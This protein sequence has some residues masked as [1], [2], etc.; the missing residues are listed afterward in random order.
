MACSAASENYGNTA[1]STRVEVEKALTERDI[2]ESGLRESFR[3]SRSFSIPPLT[4]YRNYCP[5]VYPE[6]IPDSGMIFGV[7]LVDVATNQD[8]V[9]KVIKICIEEVEKGG[10]DAKG[11]YSVSQPC[12][13]QDSFTHIWCHRKELQPV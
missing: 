8:N 3:R 7:P 6:M 4:F 1:T 13:C 12:T 11:I 10:L 5:G 9:P 2:S